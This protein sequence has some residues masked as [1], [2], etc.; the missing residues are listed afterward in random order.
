MHGVL[1]AGIQGVGKGQDKLLCAGLYKRHAM[2]MQAPTQ[3]LQRT[4]P[5]ASC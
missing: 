3:L 2:Q 5:A 1:Y 4:G